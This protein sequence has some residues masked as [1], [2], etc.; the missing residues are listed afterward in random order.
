MPLLDGA[1][2][3]GAAVA[4]KMGPTLHT[5]ASSHCSLLQLHAS[6]LRTAV[7][8]CSRVALSGNRWHSTV[9]CAGYADISGGGS[10][11]VD[12]SAYR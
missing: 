11:S 8:L 5:D 2:S 10:A 12:V 9:V 4:R 7:S 1:G 3:W 6:H